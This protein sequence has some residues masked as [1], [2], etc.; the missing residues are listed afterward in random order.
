MPPYLFYALLS[1][2]LFPILFQIIAVAKKWKGHGIFEVA[3][4]AFVFE[5]VIST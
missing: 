3:I 5:V 4:L 1:A 2:H